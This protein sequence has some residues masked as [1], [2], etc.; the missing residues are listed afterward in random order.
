M[1]DVEHS[2]QIFPMGN[3]DL[4]QYHIAVNVN[5]VSLIEGY[6]VIKFTTIFLIDSHL[7]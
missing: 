2:V 5:L 6:S 3:Y 1:I 4:P 7:R